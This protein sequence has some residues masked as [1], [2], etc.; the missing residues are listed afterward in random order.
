MC[1]I[2]VNACQNQV[3]RCTLKVQ[4]QLAIAKFCLSIKDCLSQASLENF[5]IKGMGS[6]ILAK[7]PKVSDCYETFSS[8]NSN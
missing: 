6:K 1:Y 5:T 7:R 2:T 3:K 4:V 8:Q